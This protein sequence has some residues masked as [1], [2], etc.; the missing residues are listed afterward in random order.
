MSGKGIFLTT[1]ATVL[2][3]VYMIYFTD[4][5]RSGTI[6]IVP[7]LR[8]HGTMKVELEPGMTPVYPVA[9]SFRGKYEFTSVRVVYA[10]DLATNKYPHA[11]WDLISDR[12]SKP[13][14]YL[15]Y[16]QT[17][18]GMNN[19]DHCVC[20]IDKNVANKYCSLLWISAISYAGELCLIEVSC[21]L[22]D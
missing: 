17:P 15:I 19:C 5:F 18:K 2:A 22:E 20:G 4:W 6:Q 9:F 11:L 8:V 13:T 14:E 16:G 12:S 21:V 7:T 3:V 1:I 10:E